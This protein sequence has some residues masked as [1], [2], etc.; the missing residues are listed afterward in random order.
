MPICGLEAQPKQQSR[1]M[2][3]SMRPVLHPCVLVK[4]CPDHHEEYLGFLVAVCAVICYGGLDKETGNAD[5][6]GLLE[7]D[8]VY[9]SNCERLG[10]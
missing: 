2:A 9:C 6:L 10:S 5:K 7:A 8:T 1:K 3:I 4:P